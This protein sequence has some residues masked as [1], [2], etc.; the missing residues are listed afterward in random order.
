M[1]LFLQTCS[2]PKNIQIKIS[3]L[4]KILSQITRRDCKSKNSIDN[5]INAME[6]KEEEINS[7]T[8]VTT[9]ES[10]TLE[11]FKY[12]VAQMTASN[13]GEY[14]PFLDTFEETRFISLVSCIFDYALY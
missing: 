10:G 2:R 8:L 13:V 9:Y 14:I 5:F 1:N 7:F 6:I 11:S 3:V 4:P 12:T